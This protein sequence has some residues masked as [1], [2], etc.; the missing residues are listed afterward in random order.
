MTQAGREPFAVS[1]V[2][3]SIGA[4]DVLRGT[5]LFHHFAPHMH[6]SF[7][8]GTIDAGAS[9]VRYR[10]ATERAGAGALVTISAGETHT[11][12]PDSA[13]GWSYRMIYPHR[14]TF[15][16]ALDRS[17]A[18]DESL[19]FSRAFTHD[20]EVRGAFDSAYHALE[21]RACDLA[22]EEAV[23]RFLRLLW[24]RHSSGRVPDR[25]LPRSTGVVQMAR[26]FLDAHFAQRVQLSTLA[27]M[28]GVSPFHLIRLFRAAVGIPPHAYLKQRRVAEAMTMLRDGTPVAIVAYAC[29]FSDQSHLTRAF[30]QTYGFQPGAYQRAMRK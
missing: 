1:R 5:R 23:L 29:G 17:L 25:V 27:A 24:L 14:R 10:G 28:S 12:G 26:D 3:L 9:H 13:C 15:G 2:S 16:V 7:A 18:D 19:L 21:T 4:I 20:H 30:K 11:G 8:V 22:T 6:E